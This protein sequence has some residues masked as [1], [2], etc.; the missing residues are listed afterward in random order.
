MPAQEDR[1]D[2]VS[3]G[4]APGN[5]SGEAKPAGG[6]EIPKAGLANPVQD[7]IGP[8]ASGAAGKDDKSGDVAEKREGFGLQGEDVKGSLK[9]HLKLDLEADIK[10]TARVRGDIAIGLL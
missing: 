10:V 1:K 6:Q 9:I 2:S 3:N 8:I 4:N 7:G 5:R